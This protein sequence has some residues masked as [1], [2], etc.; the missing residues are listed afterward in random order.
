MRI[1]FK[2]LLSF[3][4]IVFGYFFASTAIAMGQNFYVSVA[5]ND[6]NDGSFEKPFAS[7]ER[8]KEVV[9]KLIPLMKSDINIFIMS[10]TYELGW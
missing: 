5:G 3:I 4:F 1:K 9:K 6:S 8:A 10:G 2:L 7:I